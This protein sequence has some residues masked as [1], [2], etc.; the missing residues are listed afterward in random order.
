MLKTQMEIGKSGNTILRVMKSTMK[1]QMDFGRNVN[2]ILKVIK[3]TLRVQMVELQT[4]DPIPA[5]TK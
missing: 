1:I 4:I 5:R 3:F 2:M